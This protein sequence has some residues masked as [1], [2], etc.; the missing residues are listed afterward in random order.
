MPQASE[1]SLLCYA[2]LAKS[3]SGRT[4]GCPERSSGWQGPTPDPQS[5][6]P[7]GSNVVPF[8][9]VYYNPSEENRP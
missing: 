6:L 1:T 8:W 4:G 9:V 2:H 3:P 7:K 5:S